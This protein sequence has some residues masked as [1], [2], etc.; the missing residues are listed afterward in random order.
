[1]FNANAIVAAPAPFRAKNLPDQVAQHLGEK[2]ILGELQPGQRVLDK[3]VAEE[4]GISRGP[5][6]EAFQILERRMLL[7]LTPRH[8]AT[9]TRV[10]PSFAAWLHDVVGQLL[11]LSMKEAARHRT[12]EDVGRL[13]DV[14]RRI[15]EAAQNDRPTTYIAAVLEFAWV[16]QRAAMNPLLG[17]L[18]RDLE[19]AIRRTL[20]S[21]HAREDGHFWYGTDLLERT[22][23]Y[24]ELENAEM[25]AETLEAYLQNVKALVIETLVNRSP[26]E[27]AD[28]R[29]G[30]EAEFAK[31]GTSR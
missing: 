4:L 24:I 10:S 11:A 20:A 25:A 8:G 1:M 15:G 28:R 17:R 13:R 12:D 3:D 21:L 16:C 30:A 18:L 14:L 5:I 27:R 29:E 23:R 31:G 26:S 19:P 22:A 9:V 7:D 2:I 6:R